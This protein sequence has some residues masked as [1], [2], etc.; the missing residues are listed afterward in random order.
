MLMG[1]VAL[2]TTAASPA[3]AALLM[4][5]F[6]GRGLG[7]PVAATFQLDSNPVP[8]MTNDPGFGIQQIFFNNVPGVFNGNAETATTIA[9]GKGLAAQFQILGTSAGFAQ[10]GGDEV[11]SGTLDKPIF[12]AGTYN[13]TG[14][15]SSGTLT[16][17]EV[18]VAAAV[19]EP[20][21]WLT[22]IL[23]FGLVGVA[24]RRRVAAPA[25]G[26]AA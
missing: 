2:T 5:D 26:F 23:G 19:P 17:S 6:T 22:M 18:D 4:F 3:S 10:F 15:F 11:F 1:L 25:V 8:D 12:R 21:S 24:V 20:A 7:G 16:I 13:F 14:L 9:F